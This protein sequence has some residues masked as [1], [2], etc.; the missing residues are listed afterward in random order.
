MS[1]RFSAMWSRVT[2][3]NFPIKRGVIFMGQFHVDA[4]SLEE[5]ITM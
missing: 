3:P 4:S 1:L 5:K 2:L